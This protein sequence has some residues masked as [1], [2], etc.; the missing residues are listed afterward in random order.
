MAEAALAGLGWFE[1]PF[2]HL[3]FHT[4]PND[5]TTIVISAGL[6]E[7]ESIPLGDGRIGRLTTALPPD[8]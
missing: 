7:W 2:Q 4:G 3:R 6:M 8:A 1:R 5:S